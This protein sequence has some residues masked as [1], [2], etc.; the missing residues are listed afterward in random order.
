MLNKYY[1]KIDTKNLL[2]VIYTVVKLCKDVK[3]IVI[4]VMKKGVAY[5]TPFKLIT[6]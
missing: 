4:I 6:Q 1:K 3:L 2:L 5:A